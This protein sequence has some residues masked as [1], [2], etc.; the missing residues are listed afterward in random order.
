MLLCMESLKAEC[1]CA[2]IVTLT[3]VKAA[4]GN[5]ELHA[6]RDRYQRVDMEVREWQ[7]SSKAQ[8]PE[9]KARDSRQLPGIAKLNQ[10]VWAT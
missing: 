8:S 6:C 3:M 5:P 4:A 10:H 1:G 2:Q 7:R 9:R